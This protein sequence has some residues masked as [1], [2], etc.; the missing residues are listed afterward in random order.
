[1]KTVLFLERGPSIDFEDLHKA[2]IARG[3]EVSEMLNL[4]TDPQQL[5]KLPQLNPDCIVIGTT[6]MYHEENQVLA[7]IFRELKWIPKN[8]MFCSENSTM[9]FL[10]LAR[11]LKPH[12]TKFW[13]APMS[14]KIFQNDPLHDICWI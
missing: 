9:A 2:M 4:H 8:A 13:E 3:Y 5:R 1:M 7:Q 6:G 14:S 12:G 11:E 10:S